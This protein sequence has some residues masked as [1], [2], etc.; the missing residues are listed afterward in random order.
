MS[1]AENMS[2]Q[3]LKP[4]YHVYSPFH[5]AGEFV[6]EPDGLRGAVL[7][8]QLVSSTLSKDLQL[9]ADRPPGLPLLLVLPRRVVDL[10]DLD[11]GLLEALEAARPAVILPS[12]SGLGAR[13]M[14]SIL[15]REP[16][17]LAAE[18]LDYLF[19][20]GIGMDKETRRIVRRTVELSRTTATLSKLSKEIY[21]SRRALGR[22]FSQRGLPPPSHWL[23]FAR[24]LGACLKLQCS[25]LSLSEMAPTFG[26]PDGFTLS[27][28][29]ERLVG[30][31][32]SYVRPRLGWEWLVES[33]LQSERISGRLQAP[34]RTPGQS[35]WQDA[36]AKAGDT[37]GSASSRPTSKALRVSR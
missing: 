18:F 22:R 15:R 25:G 9:A 32:P 14:A 21:C 7:I 34:L 6:R 8:W 24:L 29:L 1:S 36:V 16:Q 17:R 35:A 2:F 23:Q 13:E 33:W 27:N 10:Q 5:E 12:A 4:P 11:A 3:L 20:R 26:Y 19:W 28:Q 37:S 30:V 31:R